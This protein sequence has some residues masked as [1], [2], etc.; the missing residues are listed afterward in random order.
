M[1]VSYNC[2][3]VFCHLKPAFSADHRWIN[4]WGGNAD[5]MKVHLGKSANVGRP[6]VREK[7]MHA[8]PPEPVRTLL[9]QWEGR[10]ERDALLI[11]DVIE[12]Q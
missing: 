9:R 7:Q 6:T 4:V 12:N 11:N 8:A 5:V 3:F 10:G 2:S 1:S